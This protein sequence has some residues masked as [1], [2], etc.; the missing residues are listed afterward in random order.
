MFSNDCEKKNKENLENI[1]SLSPKSLK[2]K[3]KLE[4]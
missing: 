1:N 2:V 4:H 3:I